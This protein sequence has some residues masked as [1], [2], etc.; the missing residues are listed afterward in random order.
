M[1]LNYKNMSEENV[2]RISVK[3]ALRSKM[4]RF[5]K[6]IPG[7]IFRRLESLICQDE[8]NKILADNC[9][10]SGS[11]FSE[12]ALHTLD[13]GLTVE[14]L[15]NIPSQG[16][17]IFASNHPLG[18]LDGI[19]LISIFGKH[20]GDENVRCLV[21]DVLMAVKPLESV[22]LPVN[23]Y[24]K[25][26][27]EKMLA[28]EEAYLSDKQIITF[29]AGLC[30]RKGD[31]GKVRDLEW[32]KSFIVKAIETQ[33]DIIPVYFSGLNSRFFYNFAR[34]RKKIGI[35]FNIELIFL[36][37][38]MVKNKGNNFVVRIG[39]PIPWTTFDNTKKKKQ[40]AAWVKGQV[41]SLMND[42]NK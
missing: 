20:F 38:E 34:V 1:W 30:S 2:V 35:K 37:R 19:A 15:E 3:D 8:L 29:P 32:Q 36:P 40:W 27:R 28:V 22:F 24:G 4:P 31:D 18:G 7:Y 42:T 26:S 25:Q 13:I 17:F 21:N 10:K 14:G 33:R 11:A 23:K 5:S 41:Y 39:K 12:G 6:W 16:R 9:G